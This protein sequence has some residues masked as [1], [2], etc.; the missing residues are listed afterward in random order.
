MSVQSVREQ[1]FNWLH[2]SGKVQ[3]T[4]ATIYQSC[5]PL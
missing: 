4:I 5:H 2:C 1:Q 3:I